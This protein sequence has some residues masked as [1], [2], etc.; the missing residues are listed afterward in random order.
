[1]RNKFLCTAS[2]LFALSSCGNSL[3]DDGMAKSEFLKVVESSDAG[4]VELSSFKINEKGAKNAMGTD[5]YEFKY[6]ATVKS[7]STCTA[8]HA[9]L[10]RKSVTGFYGAKRAPDEY[11]GATGPTLK[12]GQEIK[13]Q[14]SIVFTKTVEGWKAQ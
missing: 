3:P 5:Y 11:F 14:G 10:A 1:M 13:A 12:E 7:L 8:K 2:M 6:E 9:P 4:C